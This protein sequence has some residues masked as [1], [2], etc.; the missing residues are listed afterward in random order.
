[1]ISLGHATKDVFTM[2]TLIPT[3]AVSAPIVDASGSEQS[4]TYFAQQK[5]RTNAVSKPSA[6]GIPRAGGNSETM[7]LYF[8]TRDLANRWPVSNRTL[9]NWRQR[10]LGP[11]WTKFGSRVAYHVD[12]VLAYEAAH[13]FNGGGR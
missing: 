3:T 1:M 10:G 4:H 13:F 7:P 11:R 12:E 5:P 6:P 2:T 8:T 9:E